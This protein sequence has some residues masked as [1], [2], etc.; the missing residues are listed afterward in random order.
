MDEPGVLGA[1]LHDEGRLDPH[2]PINGRDGGPAYY[3]FHL[4]D[5][6]IPTV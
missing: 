1:N 3:F 5:T 4:N 6:E 2:G